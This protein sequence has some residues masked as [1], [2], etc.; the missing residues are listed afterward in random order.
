MPVVWQFTLLIT[1]CWEAARRV[2]RARRSPVNSC[3][4]SS[5]S[6][7]S[8][9]T[10]P[11]PR[12]SRSPRRSASPKH[13]YTSTLTD[14]SYSQWR[15]QKVGLGA[16]E[17]WGAVPPAE[18]RGQSPRWGERVKRGRSPSRSWSINAFCVSWI[19]T[20]KKYCIM[21]DFMS[22]KL[23]KRNHPSLRGCFSGMPLIPVPIGGGWKCP[24]N[25]LRNGYST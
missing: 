18:C 10:C 8:T 4:S 20:C 3:W 5:A 14:W 15:I 16:K 19:P 12:G 9:S 1:S 21:Y 25:F 22:L 23:R 11:D 13:R 2:V 17:V 7:A 6:S 24:Q